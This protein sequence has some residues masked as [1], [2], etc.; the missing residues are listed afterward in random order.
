MADD[1]RVGLVSVDQVQFHP[2]NVRADLGDLRPL[3]ASIKR[4]G[5]LQPIVVERRGDTMRLR[6]GH[7]RLAAARIAG[8][9]RL[10]AVIH[11]EA[12]GDREWVEQAIQ[13]NA[14]RS[15]MSSADRKRAIDRLR[16]YGCTWDGIGE[17]FGV[18]GRTVRAWSTDEEHNGQQAAQESRRQTFSA[19]QS[20]ARQRA[21]NRLIDAHR[22]EYEQLLTEEGYVRPEKQPG[23]R[24]P[25]RRDQLV[26][27]V[28]ELL[29]H[30]E[31]PETIAQRVGKSAAALDIMLRRAGRDDLA[32][33]FNAAARRKGVTAA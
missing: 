19:E 18:T 9:G 20:K 16:G 29:G 27:D 14:L 32:R 4:Y 5:V 21:I 13:E 11:T 3:A 2:H 33:P 17:V 30:G 25:T 23:G 22:D 10:P 28:E 15:D 1:V 24:V 31:I 8:L 26:Q 7:R 6:A 12:L